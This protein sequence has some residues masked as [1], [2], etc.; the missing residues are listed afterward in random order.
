MTKTQLLASKFF[1]D[2]T[3]NPITLSPLQDQLFQLIFLQK[4]PRI[5]VMAHTRFG[6]SL[7]IALA[8]LLRASIYPE[9]WAIISGTKEK[10]KIIMSYINYHIFDHP[11]FLTKF[12][13]EKGEK[14]EDLRRYRNK[15]KISFKI[16]KDKYSYIFIGSA[17]E[18]LGYGARN[19]VLDEAA[20]IDNDDFSLVLRMLGDN[21]KENFLC[22][23]GNP[24]RRNH[25]FDSYK[26]PKY[27][28]FNVDCW[29]SLKEGMR[30]SQE[31]IEE[32]RK[33]VYFSV[34][35]ENKFPSE[36]E[37]DEEGWVYLLTEIDLEN[38]KKRNN[39]PA[40]E[41]FLGVDVARGGRNESVWVIRDD[42][43]ARIVYRW[44][45]PDIIKTGQKTI[46]I[47]KTEG[48]NP[49]NV[50]IDDV[51]VGGGVV[52][53]LKNNG[54]PVN[55]VNFGESLSAKKEFLIDNNRKVD[56]RFINL[57]AMLYAGDESVLTW[58]RNYGQLIE[59]EYSGWDQLLSIRYKKNSYG[60]IVIEPKEN[61]RK[62]GI[63]SPDIADAF[64]LTFT[65]QL[66][67][68]KIESIIELPA[69]RPFGG[70]DWE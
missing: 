52:D 57:K 62:R 60:K 9:T 32:N 4:Y 5:H 50:Y 17:K 64:A 19:V 61:M 20:L 39:T 3:G 7:T 56:E 68:R 8:V 48:V 24:F 38:S 49:S 51:G 55:G 33:Y 69:E 1:K 27:A 47:I 30:M 14:I 58:V 66:S 26:D 12:V 36:N 70:V 46:E 59:N 31:L 23:I 40:G 41:K 54:L 10:A 25:F 34:L 29:T 11:F 37:I 18:A 45:E 53:F 65:N 13:P 63:E 44:R 22:K 28:K 21:P 42:T 35:F 15:Q 2:E 43:T 6:K 16:D 67:I